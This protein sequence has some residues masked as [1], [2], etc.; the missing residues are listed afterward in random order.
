MTV[1]S[2]VPTLEGYTFT[3]WA[4]GKDGDVMY[5]ASTEDNPVQVTLSS[6]APNKTLYAVWT[7]QTEPVATCTVTYKDAD[8]NE[9]ENA[10]QTV[11]PGQTITVK[12]ALD[13]NNS[14]GQTFVGWQD[15]EGKIHAPG[16]TITVN[17][18]ITL[19]AVWGYKVTFVANGGTLTDE[20][21]Q[22]IAA[23]AK[24]KEPTDP[25][26]VDYTFIGWYLLKEAEEAE[27]A[28]LMAADLDEEL[29]EA[30]D[31]DGEEEQNEDASTYTDDALEEDAFDFDTAITK[32]ITL[33]AKWSDGSDGPTNPGNPS[34]NDTDDAVTPSP[35]GTTPSDDT[36]IDAGTALAVAGATVGA[37]LLT[38]LI[39][40]MLAAPTEE[41]VGGGTI[42]N[43]GALAVV[44]SESEATESAVDTAVTEQPAESTVTV[45]EGD[46]AIRSESAAAVATLPQTGQLWWPVWLLSVA[47][48]A[49]L[50]AGF[51]VSKKKAG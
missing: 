8:G 40:S 14:D 44:S 35:G 6:T 10:A 50:A 11:D 24:A 29:T 16:E 45:A 28:E 13:E 22:R 33:V 15:E 25:S 51:W 49:L 21:V 41:G 27:A 2:D 18:D 48:V 46:G 34:S 12:E 43:P 20:K 37:V 38:G 3:C 23:N 30:L 42:S 47:G 36:G 26:R 4:E 7:E 32:D 17:K 39:Q 1:A 31:E 19:T 5:Q 9:I